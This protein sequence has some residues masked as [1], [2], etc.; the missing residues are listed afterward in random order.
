MLAN[1]VGTCKSGYDEYWRVFTEEVVA[2]ANGVEMNINGVSVVVYAFD[3]CDLGDT[4]AQRTGKSFS[5]TTNLEKPCR[6]CG[7]ILE[8]MEVH[9]VGKE[10]ESVVHFI[11]SGQQVP[12]DHVTLHTWFCENNEGKTGTP[13]NGM[14]LENLMSTYGLNGFSERLMWPGMN[15]VGGNRQLMD[16]MHLLSLGVS[17]FILFIY[18]FCFN[19]CAIIY[20][21]IIFYRSYTKIFPYC[22]ES[23]WREGG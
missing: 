16:V 15:N 21:Y 12:F 1:A 13:K 7:C 14:L 9:K 2:L 8:R 5:K 11:R 19:V 6:C 17:L 18:I 4:P 3:H 23:T 22:N 20:I 10:K